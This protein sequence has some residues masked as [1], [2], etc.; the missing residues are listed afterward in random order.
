MVA[1]IAGVSNE[2]PADADLYLDLGVA[3]VHGIQL[4]DQLERQYDLHVPDDDFVEATSI[5]KLT[6][7]ID[8]LLAEKSRGPA[9][10]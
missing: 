2:A 10:A 3:S 8:K 9:L 1:S 5:T 4:L 7:M 6:V